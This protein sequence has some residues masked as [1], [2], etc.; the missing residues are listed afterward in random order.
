MNYNPNAILKYLHV[1]LVLKNKLYYRTKSDLMEF[2][3]ILEILEFIRHRSSDHWV[4]SHITQPSVF[5]LFKS[6]KHSLRK[7]YIDNRHR[8]SHKG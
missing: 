6:M 3:K 1:E 5:T 2:S 4:N 8:P 7:F